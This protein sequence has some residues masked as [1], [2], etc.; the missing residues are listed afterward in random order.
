MSDSNPDLAIQFRIGGLI[1]LSHAAFAD[2]GG[3]VVMA[4]AG[5]DLEWQWVS[6]FWTAIKN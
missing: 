2:E 5:A 1:H 3:H 6:S 4:E